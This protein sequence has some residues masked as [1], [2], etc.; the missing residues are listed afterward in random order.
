L[1][2]GP[3]AKGPT[4]GKLVALANALNCTLEELT[5]AP[6]LHGVQEKAAA[7]QPSP[8]ALAFAEA[9][10]KLP[11]DDPRRK[12]IEMLLMDVIAK[13]SKEEPKSETKLNEG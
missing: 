7:H 3:R 5:G 11:E 6:T 9:L 1:R 10:E 4:L 2:G 8:Q 13:D 12:A